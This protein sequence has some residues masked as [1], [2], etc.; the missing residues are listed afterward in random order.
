MKISDLIKQ[1]QKAQQIYG[2]VS[3]VRC[4][5]NDRF[6]ELYEVTLTPLLLG[7]ISDCGG[8]YFISYIQPCMD[9]EASEDEIFFEISI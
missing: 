2:D 7:R 3:L 6:C 8:F 4:D 1:L 5:K 9:I